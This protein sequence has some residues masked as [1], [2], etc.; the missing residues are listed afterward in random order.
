MK[1]FG[2]ETTGS[3]TGDIS[4]SVT[5]TGSFGSVTIGTGA[6]STFYG[7]T[8]Q[9]DQTAGIALNDTGQGGPYQIAANGSVLY[10]RYNGENTRGIFLNSSGNVGIGGN[11]TGAKLEVAGNISGSSTSTGSFGFIEASNILFELDDNGDI[12]PV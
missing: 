12:M 1:I 9:D 5:S 7:L 2:L 8:I 11:S 10:I 4:G 3:F 6:K